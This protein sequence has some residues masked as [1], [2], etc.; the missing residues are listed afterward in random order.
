MKHDDEVCF[1]TIC[2]EHY[3]EGLVALIN[4]LVLTGHHQ[5][6]RV[7][8]CGLNER[9]KALLR[10]YG[11]VELFWLDPSKIKNPGQYKAFAHLANA[12]GIVVIIDADMI[13]TGSLAPLINQ[14]RAGGICAFPN[15]IDDRWY[16]QW[17]DIFQL[18]RPPRRQTYICSAFVAFSV[19]RWPR[20]L[21]QWWKA[22]EAIHSHPTYQEGTDWDA[23]TAQSDQ[24]ALNAVLMSEY[25]EDALSLAPVEDQVYRWDFR[26][27]ETLDVRNLR[28]RFQ[29]KTPLILHAALT[30]KPWD[31]GGA[32]ND[33][34]FKFLRRL[35]LGR[36]VTLRVPVDML[37]PVTAPGL[38]G[39]MRR[40]QY[41]LKNMGIV[42]LALSCLPPPLGIRAKHAKDWLRHKLLALRN[43]GVR[44]S[45]QPAQAG[46]STETGTG[47]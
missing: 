29:G 10:T 32:G 21:G 5:R 6:I 8:D 24:D 1:Y 3:F 13:I 41:F 25:A 15:P 7:G 35:L 9:Q 17:E 34:Y 47:D 42:E 28:C 4:S 39:W 14:A 2:D 19:D 26:L 36:D 23:P 38:M 33:T 44:P 40:Q 30:P 27:L 12:S 43:R 37:T 18:P 22:C 16:A 45:A 46:W 31:E 20:L 11:Q